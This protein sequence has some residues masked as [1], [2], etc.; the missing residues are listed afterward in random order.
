MED[1]WSIVYYNIQIFNWKTTSVAVAVACHDLESPSNAHVSA[2]C[3]WMF[4]MCMRFHFGVNVEDG[5]GGHGPV[6]AK[7]PVFLP[8]CCSIVGRD[9]WKGMG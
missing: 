1:P 7:L 2:L 4:C 8:G 9:F 3:V 5:C 6:L